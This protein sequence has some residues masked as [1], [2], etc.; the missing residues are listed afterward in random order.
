[1]DL[2]YYVVG[3]GEPLLFLGGAFTTFGYYKKFIDLLSKGY[4][5]YFFNYP[6]FGKSKK[7]LKGHTLEN[8]LKTVD[9]FVKYRKLTKFHLAGA[10]F[11][12]FLAVKYIGQAK[13]D[14]IKSLILF[15][16]ASRTQTK[17]ALKNAI[18]LIRNNLHKHSGGRKPLTDNALQLKYLKNITEK[19][20]H[21]RFVLSCS[22]EVNDV[23][24]DIPTLIILGEKD[25]LVDNKYTVDILSTCKNLQVITIPGEGHDAFAVIGD[26]ILEIINSF[27]RNIK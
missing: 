24:P 2:E 3:R 25:P 14:K 17:S 8:Y 4:K 1:M 27:T 11:G 12:G 7:F 13:S 5:V 15:S 26:K 16:P 22:L 6:G 21:A 9:D 18:R 19:I 20:K 23:H 10:S